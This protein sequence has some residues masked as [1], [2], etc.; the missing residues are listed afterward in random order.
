MQIK[1]AVKLACKAVFVCNFPS[2]GHPML[3]EWRQTIKQIAARNNH[4][5]RKVAT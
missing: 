4:N 1:T 2:D 3:L 5:Q